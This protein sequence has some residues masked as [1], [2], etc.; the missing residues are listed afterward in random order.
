MLWFGRDCMFAF[1]ELFDNI[2]RHQ[3]IQRTVIVVPIQL[4]TTVEVTVPIFGEF[5]LLL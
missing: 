1:L 5:V 3:K 4:D 2:T